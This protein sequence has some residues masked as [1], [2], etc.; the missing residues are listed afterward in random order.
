MVTSYA[1]IHAQRIRERRAIKNKNPV[2][3]IYRAFISNLFTCKPLHLI[4]TNIKGSCPKILAFSMP[5]LF[6]KEL[7]R[8]SISFA[9]F[10]QK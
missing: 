7:F 9:L 8:N 10:A 5:T 1:G 2:G 3:G 6:N 4:K